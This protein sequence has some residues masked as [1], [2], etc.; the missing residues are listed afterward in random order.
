MR[1]DDI[2]FPLWYCLEPNWTYI[3]FNINILLL[4]KIID[5]N[6]IAPFLVLMLVL[7]YDFALC[8]LKKADEFASDNTGIVVRIV[9]ISQFQIPGESLNI[10]GIAYLRVLYF[11]LLNS[12]VVQAAEVQKCY[13][14]CTLPLFHSNYTH[15][16]SGG[17]K[18]L[19]YISFR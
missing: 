16:P 1:Y 11:A 18:G 9:R 8:I 4:K 10:S 17:S 19:T 12:T 7:R 15:P 14:I 13:S 5:F 3:R 6:A 2:S